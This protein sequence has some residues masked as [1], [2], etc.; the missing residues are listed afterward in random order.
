MSSQSAA[1]SPSSSTPKR[2]FL[3]DGSGFIF[4]AYHSLPPLTNPEGTPVGAVYGFINMLHKLIDGLHADYLAV[5]FDA[6]RKTFRNELYADYKANRPEPPE[7][8]IPQFPLV[9]TATEAFNIPAIEL[10]GFEADDLIAT[11]TRLARDAGMEVVIVSSDKDL[12]QLVADGV[13]L[14]DAMKS[15]EIGTEQVLD[16]F[17]VPPEKVGDALALIGDTSDNVPGVPGIGPKTAAALIEQYGDLEGVLTH[18]EEIP[19]KKRRETLIEFAE[20]ARLSRQLVDLH[21]DVPVPMKLDELHIRKP[22][23]GT[24]LGFLEAQGF[25]SLLPRFRE[26]LG[27]SS[28]G[29][30]EPSTTAVGKSV[31]TDYTLVQNTQSLQRWIDDAFA[32][33]ICAFDTETTGLD[34]TRADLVGFSLSITPGKACYVPV[35]HIQPGAQESL[36]DDAPQSGTGDLKQIPRAKALELLKPLMESPAVLKVGQNIK[37]DM[38]ILR[39]H[40]IHIA[41]IDDTMLLSYVLDC[42]RHRHNLDAMSQRMLDITPV[43]YEEVAGKGKNK[44]SFAEVPLDEACRYAAED[45]D[46]TLRLHHILKPRLIEEQMTTVY[47]TLERP[48]VP[49]L[50]EMENNGIKADAA[51]LKG[52][53][54]DFASRMEALEKDIYALAGRE[55]TVGSPKQLGEILFDELGLPGGKKGKSGA[56]VTDVEVLEAL[57][58]EGHELPRKVLDWRQLAKLKSTYTDALLEQINPRT[59]RVH[60]SYSMAGTST[61]RLSSSDPNLQ[62]IPVRTEEGRLIRNAFIAEQGCKLISTDYSQIELRLL[63]HIADISTL[64]DAFAHGEDIHAITASQV[65]GVPVDEVDSGLRRKAKTINFG[66]IYGISAFGL[67][68]RLGIGRKEAAEYIEQYFTHYPGIRKYMERTKEFCRTHGYVQTLFGRKSFISDIH[69]KN[70]NQRNFAERAAINAPLQGTAADII[71]RAMIRLP[72]ALRDAGLTDTRILLQVHDELVLEA[73]EAQAEEAATIT[74]RVMESAAKLSVPLTVESGIGNH[75]GEIH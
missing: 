52:L 21:K 60:T 45:A 66:I 74:R 58:A 61:G 54:R 27:E 31:E 38:L 69:S 10:A 72:K 9:R 12:M 28:K 37:Y 19:Q 30:T 63:A 18:A 15:K 71:K 42:G 48:L 39:Q 3:V 40:D 7:D 33:G 59:G 65:F 13:S 47:E 34:A 8:L 29:N 56:Y 35:G 49:V 67:A 64:R 55:F 20:T 11:Y 57:A 44:R 70:P 62:N 46:L 22:E 75:W 51:Q 24:L 26:Q 43:P 6:G 4:R 36:F 1:A 53:S 73:T 2:L 50:V 16:K 68:S 5:I 41:P 25:K 23:A 14:Y 17:G 32:A